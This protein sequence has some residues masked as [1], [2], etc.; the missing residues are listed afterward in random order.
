MGKT[1]EGLLLSRG[2]FSGVVTLRLA[3]HQ[4]PLGVPKSWP[5]RSHPLTGPSSRSA[6]FTHVPGHQGAH[7][8]LVQETHSGA[9]NRKWGTWEASWRRDLAKLS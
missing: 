6:H 7:P 8:G 9:I 5:C 3:P 4:G 2:C 1:L